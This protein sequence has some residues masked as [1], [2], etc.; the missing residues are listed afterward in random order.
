MFT[1]FHG[2]SLEPKT[3]GFFFSVADCSNGERVPTGLVS[4]A[5]GPVGFWFKAGGYGLAELAFSL[6]LAA[7][8]ALAAS[9]ASS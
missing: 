7:L 8:S 1:L 5:G 9:K 4:S 2:P 3:C 6:S